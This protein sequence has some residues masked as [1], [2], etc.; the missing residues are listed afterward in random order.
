M[1][2]T[3]TYPVDSRNESDP[4]AT[5]TQPGPAR[6]VGPSKQVAEMS[7]YDHAFSPDS[8]IIYGVDGGAAWVYRSPNPLR[9][10]RVGQ[11]WASAG[12]AVGWS[13][14]TALGSNRG[15][16]HWGWRDRLASETT[17][18]VPVGV[19]RDVHLALV[20]VPGPPHARVGVTA[21]TGLWS[22]VTQ[23]LGTRLWWTIRTAV[24]ARRTITLRVEIR[25]PLQLI[26]RPLLGQVDDSGEPGG[27]ECRVCRVGPGPVLE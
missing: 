10:R 27:Q 20:Q 14:G 22:E 26:V 24:R 25:V 4:T 18:G 8:A 6:V 12:R 15:G 19:F 16:P 9:D 3:P 21:R 1:R 11:R 23:R 13:T 17:V 5:S 2:V 7:A